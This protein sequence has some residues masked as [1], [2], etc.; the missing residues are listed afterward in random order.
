MAFATLLTDAAAW[1]AL[2]D[3]YSPSPVAAAA[4]ALL[5]VLQLASFADVPL[6]AATALS[7]MGLYAV[8]GAAGATTSTESVLL[9]AKAALLLGSSVRAFALC[10]G[11]V[12]DVSAADAGG[13]DMAAAS[14]G[15]TTASAELLA[16]TPAGLF[17]GLIFI[18]L[19]RTTGYHAGSLLR[20]A[21]ASLLIHLVLRA[22]TRR[23][24]PALAELF[25]DTQ[26]YGPPSESRYPL[27][28]RCSVDSSSPCPRRS[29]PSPQPTPWLM[30][31][32][33]DYFVMELSLVLTLV[34]TGLL[35]PRSYVRATYGAAR[36]SGVWLLPSYEALL[37][38]DVTVRAVSWTTDEAGTGAAWLKAVS[39]VLVL[40]AAF[41]YTRL[42]LG[43]SSRPEAFYALQETL[44][45]IA[46]TN[47]VLLAAYVGLYTDDSIMLKPMAVLHCALLCAFGAARGVFLRTRRRA[48]PAMRPRV[49]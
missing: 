23:A 4:L 20:T 40:S 11:S 33:R 42:L 1:V 8:V 30:H 2:L 44:Q 39:I 38:A 48:L 14:G 34:I 16:G 29:H 18:L 12:R 43:P 5:L 49:G 47:A 26:C 41:A 22:G 32:W 7:W 37:Q 28:A 19:C 35:N 15:Q 46:V 45:A 17:P 36:A 9:V 6:F 25:G 3:R 27:T 24:Y 10:T 31:R 21:S 13:H